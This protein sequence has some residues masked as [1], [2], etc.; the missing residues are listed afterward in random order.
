MGPREPSMSTGE[1]VVNRWGDPAALRIAALFVLTSFLTYACFVQNLS[2]NVHSRLALTMSITRH[3]QLT[4]DRYAT[5]TN[6]KARWHGH[7]YSDKAPGLSFMAIP[8]AEV[9]WRSS[10]SRERAAERLRKDS[11]EFPPGYQRLNYAA[12][13][14]TTSF[15]VAIS[16]GALFLLSLQM[17]GNAY[18]AA[19]VAASYGFA[20][21]TFPWATTFVGHAPAGALLVLGFACLQSL[22]AGSSARCRL[23]T[24][25]IAT[26]CLT[27]STVTDFTSIPAALLIA[28]YQTWRIGRFAWRWRP[29][30]TCAAI[31]A[32]LCLTPLLAYNSLV[33]GAPWRLGYE[34]EQGFPQMHRGFL[35]I[36]FPKLPALAG[37]T[38]GAHRGIFLLCPLLILV[39]VG[40]AF[41]WRRRADRALV[42]LLGLIVGYYF[43]LNASL[44]YWDA[45]W[46]T[47]PRYVVAMLPFALLPLGSFWV[48]SARGWRAAAVI[49]AIPSLGLALMCASSGV[50]APGYDVNELRDW[51]IPRFVAGQTTAVVVQLGGLSFRFFLL[52]LAGLW[53]VAAVAIVRGLRALT[54]HDGGRL[55]GIVA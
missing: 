2:G 3:G 10:T 36:R 31:T 42:L 15:I 49:L 32:V 4:I 5:L 16:V 44:V 22:E 26:A 20:S 1:P 30:A 40:L 21:L 48:S 6:D 24:I 43:A 29:L 55:R 18:G 38:F 34:F 39:P 9:L 45:G 14:S 53:A 28:A 33:F 35:G 41:M 12:A 52:A 8:I 17:F 50:F 37:I 54:P 25:V 23:W 19:F 51:V 7:F 27:W 47:G 46:S 11:A 13:L